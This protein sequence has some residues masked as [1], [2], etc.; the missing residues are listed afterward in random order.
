VERKGDRPEG[1]IESPLDS[2]ANSADAERANL[3]ARFTFEAEPLD[4]RSADRAILP[5]PLRVGRVIFGRIQ[6]GGRF[7]AG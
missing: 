2:G 1:K 5:P 3:L 7:L 4:E 6:V